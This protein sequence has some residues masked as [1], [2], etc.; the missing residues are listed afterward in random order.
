MALVINTNVASLNSQRQLVSSGASLDRATERLSS[1]LRINSAKDDAAGL[2]IANRMTSQVRGLDQA[3]RNANDG[4]S[5]IQTAEGALQESTNI[6]QR[7]RELA[8]QSANGIYNDADRQTLDAETQQL[9]SELDRIAETTSFNGK[10]LLDGSLGTTKLQVGAQANQTIDVSI[11]SF[12]S[13]SL[14]GNA[15][16]VVGEAATGLAALSAFTGADAD[17]TLYVNDTAL[18]SLAD[19]VAGATLNEKIASIN[20]DLE[21]KGAVASALVSSEG[22]SIGD[23][24][25]VAGTDTLTLSVVDGDGNTQAYVLTGTNSMEEL[26]DKINSDTGD[27]KSVV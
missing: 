21:G 16:D 7:M 12:N 25:L 22:N 14:G 2:A 20:A 11:G 19:A 24:I 13:N 1:G 6:L 15:G 4:V 5:M 3:V 27:R 8:V 9:K 17:T 18:N 26:V 10:T 23:G